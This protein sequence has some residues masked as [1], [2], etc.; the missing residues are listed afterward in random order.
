M[1]HDLATVKA[2]ADVAE[3][4]S[5]PNWQ[6]IV[7]EATGMKFS[8]FRKSKDGILEDTSAQLKAMEQL[9]G[10]EIQIWRQDNAGE[11]KVLEENMKG[12]HSS[13]KTKFKY[14]A[15]ATSQHNSYAEM[16]FTVL[17]GR[18]RAMM[19]LENVPRDSC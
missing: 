17:A 16:G 13:M 7:D 6:L 1:Y 2:P 10:N 9:A 4:V 14:T 19:N 5:K 3:K 15:S 18:A 11:I 12:Q 8:S